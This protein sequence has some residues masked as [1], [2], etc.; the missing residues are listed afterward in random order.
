M[1]L[2]AILNAPH[3]ALI[4][5]PH[6]RPKYDDA[7][8]AWLEQQATEAFR[9]LWPDAQIGWSLKYGP[10]GRRSELDG[11]VLRGNKVILIECKWKSLTLVARRGDSDALRRDITES[12][13]KAFDQGRRARDYIRGTANPEFTASDGTVLR[14]DSQAINEIVILSVLGRGA[15]S[16]VA[17]NPLEATALGL[18]SDGELPWAL[19]IF[20]LL[21][22]C[23]TMEFG[24][25]FFDYARRRAAVIADGRFNLHDEWD[26]LEFYFAGALDI[27]DPDFA[28]KHM[29]TF[30]GS[31]RE[32]EHLVL[33]PS[34]TVPESLRR[35][36]HPKL[37]KLLK[38]LDGLPDA[39]ATDAV[40]FLLGLSDRQLQQMGEYW[41]PSRE[42]G[43]EQMA[44]STSVSGV[45]TPGGRGFTIICGRGTRDEFDRLQFLCTLNK[46]KR[47][48]PIWLG[49]G[50]LPEREDDP[51][52]V[53]LDSRP[54]TPDPELDR[55]FPVWPPPGTMGNQTEG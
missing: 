39:Q 27:K 51:F 42:Q 34:A 26:L 12:I 37:R 33:D 9:R 32:L 21:A 10:K 35:R 25:Q 53:I 8:A 2:E 24:G 19:S 47:H 22:V 41:I 48:A 16:I 7:R 29:V 6:Y 44:N 18:F 5:D 54:W 43:T 40:V 20:D 15:L 11:L 17:A 31:G 46:Y 1:L 3:Y 36:I 28:D 4:G 49:I 30:T 23:R 14:F 45:P 13:L 52:A 38:H 50:A 55:L